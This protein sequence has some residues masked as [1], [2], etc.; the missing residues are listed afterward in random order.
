MVPVCS[1]CDHLK[2]YIDGVL[3]TEADPD[4]KN[5]GHLA[6]PPFMV[7]LSNLP[8]NPWGDLRIDGYIDGK[9]VVSKS[10][11]GKGVDAQLLV[12]PD[13]TELHGDGIDVTRVLFRVTDQYGNTQQFASGAIQL[14]L[15][16]PGEIVGENPFGL[17]AGAGAVW[18]RT[19]AADGIIKLTAKH[20]YL[21]S[22]QIAI[23]VIAASAEVV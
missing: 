21:P 4:R 17:V 23:T 19:K 5:Y 18:I 20:Q 11:S 12:E 7:D 9:Q 14:S 6:H 15:E 1:N 3:K 8:L 16:G 22:K 2:L 13:D 10:Y